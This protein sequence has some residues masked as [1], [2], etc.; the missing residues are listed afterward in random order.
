MA[1][2][3]NAASRTL[4][5]QHTSLTPVSSALLAPQFEG[6][7]EADDLSRFW[8]NFLHPSVN[9]SSWTQEELQRL[10][11]LVQEHNE[12]D[13]QSVAEELGVRVFVFAWECA[14]GECDDK[15]SC[16]PLPLCIC[17]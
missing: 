12:R 16:V 5:L 10:D 9:K 4:A 1:I 6:T 7:R 13:W 14:Y 2:T 15:S 8:R 11:E 17:L 3:I